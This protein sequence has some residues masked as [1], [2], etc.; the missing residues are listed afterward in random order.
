MALLS[1]AYP[2]KAIDLG[3]QAQA[4]PLDN[5]V[6]QLPDWRWIHTP[7]HTRGHISLYREGDGVLIAG[8]AFVTVEQESLY[9][10]MTQKQEVHGPPA[11]FT[12]DWKQSEESVRI[13][14]ALRPTIAATG[15]GTPMAGE[16]LNEGLST[17]VSQFED[18]AIPDRGRYVASD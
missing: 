2:N 8:D 10:V 13:L 3:S 1:F 15:H 17:L 4:L 7:G 6:P 11:Y 9:K 16:A 12:P 14:H 18:V 5:V